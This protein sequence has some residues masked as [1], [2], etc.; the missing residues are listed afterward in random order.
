M[1]FEDARVGLRAESYLSLTRQKEAEDSVPCGFPITLWSLHL[2][3]LRR[4][5]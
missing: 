1:F 3:L 4:K 5:A 2:R